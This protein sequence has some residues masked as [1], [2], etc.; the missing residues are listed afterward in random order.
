MGLRIFLAL[1]G[2]LLS[3]APGFGQTATVTTNTSVCSP[4][5]GQI[6]F[7][8]SLSYPTNAVPS[9]AVK[10]PTSTWVYVS[11]SGANV[12][13]VRPTAG[14]TTDPADSASDF[15]FSY[16]APPSNSVSF[17][18]VLSYP[19]GL[20]GNQVM[21]LSGDYRL[22]G[23]RTPYTLSAITLTLAAGSNPPTI[24]TQP[25]GA[26]LAVNQ[27][28]TFTVV[29]SNATGPTYQWRKNGT[30]IAGATAASYTIG[31]VVAADAGSYD[32]LVSSA[33][34]SVSSNAA[35]LAVLVAPSITVQPASRTVIQGGAATFSITATGSPAPTYQWRKNGTNL[36]GATQAVFT[37]SPVATADAGSY[38]VVI[39]NAAG[40]VTSSAA[41]L[42]VT[43]GTVAPT[44]TTPPASQSVGPGSSAAFSVQAAGTTPLSYQWTRNGVNVAGATSSILFLSGVQ[45]GDAGTYAVVVT[46]GAGS[47]ISAGATLTVT[48]VT[49]VTVPPTITIHPQG[50]TVLVGE[51]V[52]LSVAATGTAPLTYQWRK[53]SVAV[54]GATN[55][56]LALGN[57]Q[58]TDGGNYTVTVRNDLD[59]TTSNGAVIS[60]VAA[61]VAP[62]IS[63]QPAGQNVTVGGPAS[64]TVVAAGTAPLT[65]QWFKDGTRI[66]GATSATLT[67]SN[68]QVANAGVYTVTV[69]NTAGSVTSNAAA[70]AVNVIAPPGISTQPGSQSA[71]AGAAVVF[72]VAANGT[73]PLGYQWRKDGTAISG[74]TS[75]SLTLGNIQS[76][77]AGAYT[78]VV[79][80]AAGSITSS[81][82]TLTIGIPPGIAVQP[83]DQI[84]KAGASVGFTVTATG[85][86][87]LSYQWNK[88][89]APV[90]GATSASLA[91]GSVQI[92][93][94]G[95]YTVAVTAGNGSVTSNAAIL[96]VVAAPS[97]SAQPVDQTVLPGS[98]AGFSVAA[99]G[100]VPLLFQW[101]KDGAPIAGA[102][103]ATLTLNAVQASQAGA[104][105]VS[106]SNGIGSV[107]SGAATLTVLAPPSLTVSPANQKVTAGA[108]TAF[109]VIATGSA[110]LSYQWRKDGVAIAGATEA[111][112]ALGEVQAAD[113]GNYA[114][115]VRNAAGSVTSTPAVLTVEAFDPGRMINLSI[116]TSLGSNETMTLGIVIGG[117]GTSG[118]KP[119]LVRAA[120]PALTQFGVTTALADP[121]LDLLSGQS[122]VAANDNWG[123]TAALRAAF[124]QVGA[125]SFASADSA[126]A[127][128]FTP[129]LAAGNY[130][131]QISGVGGAT[132]MLI[133]ELYDATAGNAFTRTT[134]RLANVSVLK[135]IGGGDTLTAG[136]VIG[137]STSRQVLIRAVG[138]TLGASPFN[139]PG[140]MADPKLDLFRGQTVINSNDNWGGGGQLATAFSN[141]GAFALGA[142]SRDAALLVTLSPG[143]YTAQVS[144]VGGASGLTLVEIYEVP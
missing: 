112:L 125:F 32:V 135:Q 21:K 30:N 26:T 24:V 131:I 27:P 116:L 73:G 70:L 14:D 89:G 59:S 20:T 6:T 104:Y 58:A 126:D 77:D 130:T 93:D 17:S 109:T 117:A 37:V 87:P 105:M 53:D 49:P 8:V 57:L 34:G 88:D 79:T 142:T 83:V 91:L 99:T 69:T 139:V 47:V 127:A 144:G 107:T 18:F 64:F 96:T 23:V 50:Q 4:S 60:V 39:A 128:V 28:A 67:V 13:S 124:A 25:S 75:A 44:I 7:N 74:A 38:D 41:T 51:N 3:A 76:S 5:G 129:P 123:G 136:F 82:A 141:V 81:A 84:V 63:A 10:P 31:S 120:G 121:K 71:R 72:T 85:T 100:T 113:A 132:G 66:A 15:G 40:T 111:T 101:L 103:S 43:P 2:G 80:N 11:D 55:A 22:N 62:T 118:S 29:V 122:V 94:A 119:V 35:V 134:P 90:S 54:L 97:I 68:V 102:T 92:S 110:P 12:P 42:S 16:V 19:A 56:T 108:R 143:S 106:V 114:V 78:V 9:V 33:G 61:A 65:Y 46:N 45:A 1:V 133:A 36:S 48:P 52:T 138:P 137:G 98:G 115:T 140:T 86:P 95:A